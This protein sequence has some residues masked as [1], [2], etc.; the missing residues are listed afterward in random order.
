MNCRH[1]VKRRTCLRPATH[2]ELC[3]WHAHSLARLLTAEPTTWLGR[4]LRAVLG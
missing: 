3:T 4:L 1:P 2:G